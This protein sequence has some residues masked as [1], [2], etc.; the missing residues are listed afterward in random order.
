MTVPALQVAATQS[1]QPILCRN[2]S[3]RKLSVVAAS[4]ARAPA[5]SQRGRGAL[6]HAQQGLRLLGSLR[7]ATK[8]LAPA[9]TLPL[10]AVQTL[11][12]AALAGVA[13]AAVDMTQVA[14]D[15]ARER[16]KRC[17]TRPAAS[18]GGQSTPMAQAL[19]PGEQA[20]VTAGADQQP[21]TAAAQ[22]SAPAPDAAAPAP[23]SPPRPEPTPEAPS[24]ALA[25]VRDDAQAGYER[26]RRRLVRLRDLP[27]QLA[28]NVL[29]S[30][31]LV[32][33]LGGAAVVASLVPAVVMPALNALSAGLHL[34]QG[35][36]EWRSASSTL[37]SAL[38]SPAA[39]APH[40]AVTVSPGPLYLSLQ[41]LHHQQARQRVQEASA[42]RA[43]ARLRIVYAAV[44]TPAALAALALTAA[45]SAAATAGI[46]LLAIGI[47]AAV[48]GLAWTAYGVVRHYRTRQ[49]LAARQAGDAQEA[50]QWQA[51]CALPPQ[52][53]EQAYLQGS[54][55]NR[56]LASA[57]LASHLAATPDEPATERRQAAA[58]FLSWAGLDPAQCSAIAQLGTSGRQTEAMGHIARMV[59]GLDTPVLANQAGADVT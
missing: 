48:T 9:G 23:A 37:R 25:P 8:A 14:H 19:T 3:S 7:S 38:S 36:L 5:P 42:A 50:L 51:L 59:F 55:S 4:V 47:V 54:A 58:S 57:L 49:A 39:Q 18:D 29:T 1:A 52:A 26:W 6:A 35:I 15:W 33:W 13:L 41:L 12:L 24:P 43:H 21:A 53:Q 16:L 20:A 56:L 10:V 28:K 34:V 2:G 32:P 40:A 44:S 11:E 46:A 22:T 17:K 31:K 27:L 45:A 30:M